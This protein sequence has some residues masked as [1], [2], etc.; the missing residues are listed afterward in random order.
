M[1]RLTD[2]P[3]AMTASELA[4]T[5]GCS[6]QAIAKWV[7]KGMPLT[8][9]QDASAWR[10]A[11]GQRAPR[12]KVAV[13]AAAY[14]DPG[15]PVCLD[16]AHVGELPE[17]TE[18]RERANRARMAEHEAMRL[19]DLAKSQNDVQ[20]IRLALEKVIVT[21]ERARDAGEELKKARAVAGIMMTKLE[22]DQVVERMAAE[23]QRGMEALVNKAGRLAGKSEPEIHGI[24][25]E[26]TGRCYESIKARMIA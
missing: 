23:F 9:E 8:S 16:T 22:H 13:A 6:R 2:V 17:V 10:A 7:I 4:K 20:G 19:L 25:R 5:W 18:I 24:L 11:N 21:Q 1:S 3:V 12:C 15:V 26:E 14:V